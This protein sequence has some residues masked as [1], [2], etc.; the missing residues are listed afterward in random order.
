[1]L[2]LGLRT[3]SHSYDKGVPSGKTGW[4]GGTDKGYPC[5]TQEA[6]EKAAISTPTGLSKYHPADAGSLGTRLL[7]PKYKMV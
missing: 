6:H 7:G 2:P 3:I 5:V 1:L 4:A